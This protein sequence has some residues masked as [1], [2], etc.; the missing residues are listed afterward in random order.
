VE[1]HVDTNLSLTRLLERRGH[2]VRSAYDISS[3]LEISRDFAFDILI[4]DMG[5]PDG[6][7]IDL[8]QKLSADRTVTGLALSGFGTE[9]DIRRSKEAGFHDHLTKP[10]DLGKLEVVIQ[11]LGRQAR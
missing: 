3:A 9:E 10:V 6:T 1:D 8:M 7:G 11:R 5:L 2:E 4:S